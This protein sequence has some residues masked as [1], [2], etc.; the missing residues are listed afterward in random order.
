[1]NSTKVKVILTIQ[2]DSKV[3]AFLSLTNRASKNNFFF[4]LTFFR[5]MNNNGD[6]GCQSFTEIKTK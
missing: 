6:T 2:G 1:M 3:G 5:N 4:P